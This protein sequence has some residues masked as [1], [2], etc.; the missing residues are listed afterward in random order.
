[1]QMSSDVSKNISLPI[2]DHSEVQFNESRM[3]DH[4]LRDAVIDL[5]LNVKVRN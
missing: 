5:Y 1:M 3:R 4:S 2:L